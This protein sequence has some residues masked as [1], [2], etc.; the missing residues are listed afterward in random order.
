MRK[1]WAALFGLTLLAMPAAQAR[2]FGDRQDARSI[3]FE[4]GLAAGGREGFEDARRGVG[5]DYRHDR[6]YRQGDRGYHRSMGSRHR[7]VEGYREGFEQ[8]YK[9]AWYRASRYDHHRHPYQQRSYGYDR[10][11]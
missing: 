7:Y 1:L 6:D 2:D 11:Y 8:G 5:L 9:R 4:R 10:R 3:G